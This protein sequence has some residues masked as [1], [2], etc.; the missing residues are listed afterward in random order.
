MRII[1]HLD[2]DAFFASVEERDNPRFA[3]RPIAV[4]AD[5]EDG[6]GRGV[7]STANY[8]AREYGIKSALPI[9]TAWK[10]AEAARLA[11][12][13]AV[14]FV[15]GHYERYSEVSH[16]IMEI[17]LEYASH[18]EQASVDEAY[19]DLSEAGSYE[20]AEEI[21]KKIK[22]EIRSR[23]R[24]TASVGIG[25]N[26][27]IAKIAS[28]R[29]KPDGL[30]VVREEAAEKF[31]EPLSVRAIPGVGPKTEAELKTLRISKIIDA[32]NLSEAELKKM[33][34][35]WGPELYRKLRGRD[36]AELVE[37]WEAKSIGEQETFA[38]DIAD[39]KIL[40]KAL[41]D[42]AAE[43]CGRFKKSDFKTYKSVTLIMR[44]SDFT[45]KT[46]TTT[47]AKPADDLATLQFQIL[48]LS[49]PFF[50]ARENPNKKAFRLIGVRLEK[51]S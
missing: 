24:L 16:R 6:R 43:V 26:K 11:G 44:F 34:G 28:D 2:M 13:P 36:D 50:D 51:L 20:A 37:S 49:M 23:E 30:T 19:F 12:K 41:K 33:M 40:N 4:G 32:K 8:K 9:S 45:T 31:L 5:P 38:K 1:G 22:A 25:P 27:L 47:L 17:L 35:K 21:A 15:E 42:L 46:R 3:G 10:F 14:I 7:V 39:R 29:Q 48:R 18:I